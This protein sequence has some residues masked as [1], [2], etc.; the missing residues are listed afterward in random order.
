MPVR[1]L[2]EEAACVDEDAP[3]PHPVSACDAMRSI[4]NPVALLAVMV[5]P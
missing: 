1:G 3:E 5:W 4:T 2:T